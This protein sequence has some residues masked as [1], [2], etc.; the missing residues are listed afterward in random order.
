[1]H[2]HN[3]REYCHNGFRVEIIPGQEKLKV[4]TADGQGSL[5]EEGAP[6]QTP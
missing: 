2:R 5:P 6:N 1:M 3:L 4:S